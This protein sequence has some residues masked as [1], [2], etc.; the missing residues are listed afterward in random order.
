MTNVN[1]HFHLKQSTASHSEQSE[2]ETKAQAQLPIEMSFAQFFI[3]IA[4]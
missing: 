4:N 3:S 1:N 2:Y